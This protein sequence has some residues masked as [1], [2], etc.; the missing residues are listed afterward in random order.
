M[1]H[2]NGNDYLRNDPAMEWERIGINDKGY[3]GVRQARQV[4]IKNIGNAD[5][6]IDA[7]SVVYKR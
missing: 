3:R 7:V 5:L 2:N 1:V 6:R 4:M